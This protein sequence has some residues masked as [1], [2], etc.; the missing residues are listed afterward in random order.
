MSGRRVGH[1]DLIAAG[2][3]TDWS[4]PAGDSADFHLSTVDRASTV[5]PTRLALTPAR[6]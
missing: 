2:Y 1:A 4:L 6:R 5:W 3:F